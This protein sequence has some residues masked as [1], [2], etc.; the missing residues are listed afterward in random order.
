MA[1][2]AD[3]HL[4][5]GL[6]ALQVG[7]VDQAQLVAAFQAWVRDKTRTLADLS[8]RPR[9]LWMPKAGP[10]S[11][12][13]WPC[14]LRSTVP[15]PRRAWRPFRPNASMRERLAAL[16]DPELTG[17]VTRLASGS[18]DPDAQVTVSY[19]DRASSSAVGTVTSDGQRFQ[20]AAAPRPAAAWG[21]SSWRLTASCIARSHSSRS[22]IPTPTTPSA[23]ADL[24]WK[25]RSPAA[26]EHPGNRPGLRTGHLP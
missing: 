20:V 3:G 6:I 21:P 5:F 25:P 12:R 14:T 11:T 23:A 10:R 16:G 26:L 15:M 4:L 18:A 1:A 22:W 8:G 13:W 24:S 7:L 19:G 17:T 9:R 2:G